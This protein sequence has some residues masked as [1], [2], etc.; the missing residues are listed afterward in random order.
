M[1]DPKKNELLSQFSQ[2]LDTISEENR[3]LLIRWL[4]DID[5]ERLGRMIYGVQVDLTKVLSNF[6][7]NK[8]NKYMVLTIKGHCRLLELLFRR[9][10][11]N[12]CSNQLRIRISN[13]QFKNEAIMNRFKPIQQFEAYYNGDKE[14]CF[15]YYP[16]LLTAE[17]KNVQ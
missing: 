6:D 2:L 3:N 11:S 12:K 5:G 1:F 17:Y 10:I 14:L 9:Y 16:F 4:I 8:P 15:M 13:D 7:S